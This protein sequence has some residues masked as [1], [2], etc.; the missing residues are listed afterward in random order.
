MRKPFTKEAAMAW[1]EN[2]CS[3]GEYASGEI[4][5]RLIRK[6]LPMAQALQ[7]VH[8]LEERRYIDDERFARAFVREKT[9]LA[10]WGKRKVRV[11]LMCKRIDSDIIDEALDEVDEEEYLDTLCDLLRA[12][13]RSLR[14]DM[15][16]LDYPSRTKLYRFAAARGYESPAIT[17]ALKRL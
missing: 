7:I 6:G 17:E 14:L 10:A 8:S 4:L 15:G 9:V 2:I 13:A 3:R 11:A 5:D 16:N 1:A 12:K